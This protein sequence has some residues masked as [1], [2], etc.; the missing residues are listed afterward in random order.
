[1]TC[2]RLRKSGALPGTEIPL[3]P[4]ILNSTQPREPL[5]GSPRIS[6]YCNSFEFQ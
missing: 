2:F 6:S 5:P 1:M 4:S 3:S